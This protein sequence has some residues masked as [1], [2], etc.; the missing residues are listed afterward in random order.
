VVSVRMSKQLHDELKDRADR[1]ERSLSSQ[2]IYYL[3]IM[4]NKEMQKT[5]LPYQ[6]RTETKEQTGGEGG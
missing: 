1:K 6:E 3:K 5:E 2:I 4:A